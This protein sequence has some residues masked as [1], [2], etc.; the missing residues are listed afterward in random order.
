MAE[1]KE[2]PDYQ[3]R[4][5]LLYAES[6]TDYSYWGNLYY[7]HGRYSDALD[8]FAQGNDTE[9][10]A[11]IKKI[12]LRDGDFYLAARLNK[13]DASMFSE[14][15]WEMLAKKAESLG[16]LTFAEWAREKLPAHKLE[17]EQKQQ[18]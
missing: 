1:K 4:Q 18:D 10:L 16:K 3:M 9:G 17:E 5:K 7:E 8:F 14:S 6:G 2:L 11:S 12:A 13:I 15:D